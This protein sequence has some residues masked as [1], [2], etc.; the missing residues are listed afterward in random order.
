MLVLCIT[1]MSVTWHNVSE[2][3]RLQSRVER[4]EEEEKEKE[5]PCT[6]LLYS[7]VAINLETIWTT[8]SQ[9]HL[10]QIQDKTTL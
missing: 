4:F 9:H 8:L 3:A 10:W 1:S 7:H 5:G 2:V 6:R